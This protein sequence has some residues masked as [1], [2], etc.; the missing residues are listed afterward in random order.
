M[1][2]QIT[3]INITNPGY[4]SGKQYALNKLSI[5]KAWEHITSGPNIIIGVLD[6][7]IPIENGSLTHPE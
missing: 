1:F 4:L 2:A 3:P 5:P 6:S 7:G